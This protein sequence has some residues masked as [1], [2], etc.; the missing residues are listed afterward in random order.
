MVKQ[1]AKKYKGYFLA[2]EKSIRPTTHNNNQQ[3][4]NKQHHNLR[5]SY[6]QTSPFTIFI[7]KIHP[8][9]FLFH[10]P[11]FFFIYTHTF[12]ASSCLDNTIVCLVRS[13]TLGNDNQQQR[14]NQTANNHPQTSQ[15]LYRNQPIQSW[16]TTT[17]QQWGMI[18]SPVQ[19]QQPYYQTGQA[20]SHLPTQTI[21]HQ[22]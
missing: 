13:G 2:P 14:P 21:D 8:L 19:Q 15:T 18:A 17:N 4:L 3:Q 22:P 12:L 20:Y 10:A 16:P 6:Q 7:N 1:K 9:R 5:S 11:T